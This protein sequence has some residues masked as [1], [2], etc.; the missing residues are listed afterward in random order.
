MR[1]AVLHA[2]GVIRIEDRSDPTIQAPTDAI[3]RVTAACC[4]IC[5]AGFHTSCVHREYVGAGG[6]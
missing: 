3:I 5:R 4:D 2:P 1:G 6:A